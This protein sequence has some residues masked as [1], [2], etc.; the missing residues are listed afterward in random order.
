[1]PTPLCAYAIAAVEGGLYVFGGW[2]GAHYVATTYYY[3]ATR[4]AWETR[5]PLPSARGFAAAA[6]VGERIYVVGGQ[7]TQGEY[8]ACE[9]YTPALDTPGSVAWQAH[10]PMSI[11]RAGHSA[12]VAEGVLYVIGGGWGSLAPYNERYDPVSDAWSRFESPLPGEWRSLGLAAVSN[13]QGTFLYALGG[14]DGNYMS[15]VRTYQVTFRTYI[16]V[17]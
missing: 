12:V 11:G 6:T 7:D 2:D 9:S 13:A 3:D 15:A 5:Q 4:D 17:Q 14:W 10:A 8:A 1:L 16:P